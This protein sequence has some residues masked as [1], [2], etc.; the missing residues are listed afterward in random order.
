VAVAWNRPRCPQANGVVERS[1]GTGKRWAEP[2]TCGDAAELRRRLGEQDEIQRGRYPS[3]GGLSRM[4]AFPGLAHSGRAYRAEAEAAAWDRAAVLAH[5]ADYVLVRRVSR[6]GTV[7]VYNRDRY[8]GKALAGRDVYVSLD[9]LA[10]EWVYTGADGA[11]YRRQAAEE[12]TADRIRGLDVSRR[13]DRG[14]PERRK[15]AAPLPA[16]P[17]CA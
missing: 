8:V 4:A 9:P 5:L 15:E 7:S 3:I 6:S 10:A 11:C 16:Q 12:L 13:R 17:P 14:D 2:A 1:Q